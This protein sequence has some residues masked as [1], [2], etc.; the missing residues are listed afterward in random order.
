MGG[1]RADPQPA[2]RSGSEV[3]H[4]RL[5]GVNGTANTLR[6]DLT[7]PIRILGTTERW[8]DLS[9]FTAVNRLGNLQRNALVGP[10]FDNLDVSIAKAL[11]IGRTRAQ[12]RADIFNLLNHPNLGQPGQVVGSPNFGRV[13]NT[14]FPSGDVGS[15]RQIQLAARVDF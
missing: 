1:V 8:F 15:S 6:P 2:R 12:L 9:A 4:C 11:R 7:G 3:A 13:S 10:R 14:R 5:K